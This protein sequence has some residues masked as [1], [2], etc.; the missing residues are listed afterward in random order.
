M[1]R[2][3]L[4]AILAPLLLVCCARGPSDGIPDP[5]T[6]SQVDVDFQDDEPN[7]TPD[8]ATPLGVASK[9]DIVIWVGLNDIGGSDNPADYFVFESGPAPSKLEFDMCYSGAI[10][11]MTATLWKVVDAEEQ[12][13]PV[14]TWTLSPSCAKSLS[15][16]LEASTEYLFGVLATG[17]PGVYTA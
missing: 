16:P 8:E 15:A 7:N 1:R 10:T 13:P 17:G 6:G 14:A 9:G 4:P 11:G 2:S 12:T 5:G 3:L